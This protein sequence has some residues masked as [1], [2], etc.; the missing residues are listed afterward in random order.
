MVFGGLPGQ[1]G[2]TQGA[3]LVGF[4]QH[5]IASFLFGSGGDQISAGDQVVVTDDLHT[6]AHRLSEGLH[7]HG[8]V[9]GEG[10]FDRH[11]RVGSQPTQKHF[12]PLFGAVNTLIQSQGVT[13]LLPEFGSSHIHRDRHLF[14]VI[15]C[16][17]NGLGEGLQR[18]FVGGEIG[19]PTTFIGHAMALASR[20]HDVASGVVDV[21]HHQHRLV[22]GVRA[23][24]HDQKIL[25][26]HAATSVG[27]TT[28]D[29][30]LR[31]WQTHRLALRQVLPKGQASRCGSGM[32]QGQGGGQDG[33]GAETLF[34][35]GA[36]ELDKQ[37][38][39]AFLVMRIVAEQGLSD[40]LVHMGHGLQNIAPTQACATIAFFHGFST[41]TRSAC[42]RSANAQTAIVQS[43]IDLQRGQ[44]A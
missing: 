27:T 31:Q 5:R 2:F 21:G 14:M 13:A 24:W 37:P 9:F 25:D 7:A 10:V 35:F 22:K 43:H 16:F 28:K 33:V 11:N 23:Q 34:L 36:I 44:A 8:V 41:A 38:V 18:F 26:V 3:H 4:E 12:Q 6:L 1:T 20:L 19:P 15:A 17:L 42:R 32:R 30:Y 29:L 39:C 40:V